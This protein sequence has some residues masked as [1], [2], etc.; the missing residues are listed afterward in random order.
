MTFFDLS[1][2]CH[3]LLV[4]WLCTPGSVRALFDELL[5]LEIE[6]PEDDTTLA[7]VP[8]IDYKVDYELREYI[9]YEIFDVF[10]Y[11]P[12]THESYALML[13]DWR[14][15]LGLP[16]YKESLKRLDNNV[17]AYAILFELSWDG[18][19]Y[20]ASRETATRIQ[21]ELEDVEDW[22]EYNPTEK[23]FEELSKTIES[24]VEEAEEGYDVVV[25]ENKGQGHY[26]P[27]YNKNVFRPMPKMTQEKLIELVG[28]N[29]DTLG[30][31]G[32]KTIET[33]N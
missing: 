20:E 2:I 4:K 26:G 28:K 6:N 12:T 16:V 9:I 18:M 30:E 3:P 24:W 32:I 5:T 15:L 29:K 23:S 1:I 7:V 17:L 31:Y 10:T 27:E 22:I 13:Q 8:I 21:K 14:I 33:C 25:L 19:S 11:N